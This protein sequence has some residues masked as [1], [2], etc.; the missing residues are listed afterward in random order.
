MDCPYAARR[1]SREAVRNSGSF[2][3][4]EQRSGSNPGSVGRLLDVAL[5]EQRGY[6]LLFFASEN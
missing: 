4:P 3:P 1:A 5:G 2:Q 6:R